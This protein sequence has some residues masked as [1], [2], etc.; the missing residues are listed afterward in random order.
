LV[1]NENKIEIG[2][3]LGIWLFCAAVAFITRAA[4][5]DITFWPGVIT[6][7]VTLFGIGCFI[8]AA[9]GEI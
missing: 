4:G 2:L 9:L 3:P 5:I 7:G 1:H 6:W 8:F